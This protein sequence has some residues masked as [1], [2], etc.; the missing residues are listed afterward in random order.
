[1][2][3]FEE[4]LGYLLIAIGSVCVGYLIGMRMKLA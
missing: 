4:P 1:M 3:Q 2:S